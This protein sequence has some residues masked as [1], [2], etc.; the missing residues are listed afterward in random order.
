MTR[1]H[2][3]PA[4][5][6]LSRSTRPPTPSQGYLSPAAQPRHTRRSRPPSC[7]CRG[8]ASS[9]TAPA[10]TP[11]RGRAAAAAA[12]AAAPVSGRH[13]PLPPLSSQAG[14]AKQQ[15]SRRCPLLPLPDGEGRRTSGYRV[16][17]GAAQSVQWPPSS[18]RDAPPLSL[19]QPFSVGGPA[20]VFR[21]SAGW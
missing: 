20:R 12:A 17:A 9:A 3:R 16:V 5:Q 18:I 15:P 6:T 1:T 7:P 11:G 2:S 14:L 4:P 10:R 19:L 8:R 13:A 21:V